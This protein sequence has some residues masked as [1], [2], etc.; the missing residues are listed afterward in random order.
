[1]RLDGLVIPAQAGGRCGQ[2][3]RRTPVTLVHRARRAEVRPVATTARL[4]LGR[5][6]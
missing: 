5:Q 3:D 2:A 1:M 6:T 4:S